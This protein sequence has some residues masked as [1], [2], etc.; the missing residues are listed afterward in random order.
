MY[1]TI[2]NTNWESDR[3]PGIERRTKRQQ[4]NEVVIN[5]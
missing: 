2:E 3:F 5:G 1:A 4:K